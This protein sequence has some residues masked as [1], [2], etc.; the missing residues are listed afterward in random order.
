MGVKGIDT[1]VT[2]K[3]RARIPL[4][5]VIFYDNNLRTVENRHRTVYEMDV[6]RIAQVT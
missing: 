1:L 2:F 4:G 6:E 5:N 3:D